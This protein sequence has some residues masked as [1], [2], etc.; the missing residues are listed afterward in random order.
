V[1]EMQVMKAF[2][3]YCQNI[4][5]WH[6]PPDKDLMSNINIPSMIN[7]YNSKYINK[8]FFI[9]D[10]VL[11]HPPETFVKTLDEQKL[12][13]LLLHPIIW[14]S[15]QDNMIAMVCYVLNGII[16]DCDGE[17]LINRAWKEKYPEGIPQEF[18]DI[19]KDSLES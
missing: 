6:A 4:F 17:F 3:P 13:H 8:M 18:L 12:I 10:S 5:V 19:L 7:A 1:K 14:M 9:S 16:S 11:R 15:E 2:F